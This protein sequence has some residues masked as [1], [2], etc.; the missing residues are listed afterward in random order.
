MLGVG[1]WKGHFTASP[2]PFLAGHMTLSTAVNGWE[3]WVP[4]WL[5]QIGN[6]GLD[7]K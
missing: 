5:G 1:T 2:S 6:L 3:A 7:E 4:S